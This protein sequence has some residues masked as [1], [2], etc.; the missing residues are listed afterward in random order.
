MVSRKALNLTMTCGDAWGDS[1]L[2][3]QND[4]VKRP[5]LQRLSMPPGTSRINE[6]EQTTVPSPTIVN[7]PAAK[8][9]SRIDRDI[10]MTGAGCVLILFA[11]LLISG[12]FAMRIISD[13]KTPSAPTVPAIAAVAS[14]TA[15]DTPIPSPTPSPTPESP[16]TPLPTWTP[17]GT[18]S[19]VYDYRGHD[20]EYHDDILSMGDFMKQSISDVD[21]MLATPQ[22]TNQ[23]WQYNI[24]TQTNVWES[25]F[26]DL[27]ATIPPDQYQNFHVDVTQAMS[28]LKTAADDVNYA[29]EFGE[30]NRLDQAKTEITTGSKLL[31]DALA[32]FRSSN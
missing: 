28:H 22:P 15:T 29:I 19:Q 5:S 30:P 23:N 20:V 14:P 2:D 24:L 7:E 1:K 32:S 16:Y 3:Q 8:S 13:K 31:S 17:I 11:G 25:Y 21:K 10:L 4:R 26:A 27:Q 18:K 9:S 6:F 12:V